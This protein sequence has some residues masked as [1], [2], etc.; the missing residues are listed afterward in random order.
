MTPGTG[1]GLDAA[2]ASGSSGTRLKIHGDV[3]AHV[4]V[5]CGRCLFIGCEGQES[6]DDSERIVAGGGDGA[7]VST[8]VD[9]GTKMYCVLFFA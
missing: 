9:P 6:L 2:A 5:K 3:C 4:V 1:R 7:E 8:I